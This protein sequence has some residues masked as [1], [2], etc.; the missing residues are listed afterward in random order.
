MTTVTT[1]PLR[2]RTA[3]RALERHYDAIK[4]R[5]LRDLFAEDPSRG[6]RLV[7]E[8]AGILLD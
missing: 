1:T 5:H 7:A 3:W 4:G 6:G 2:R 8:G